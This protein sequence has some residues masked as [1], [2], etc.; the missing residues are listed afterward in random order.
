M[1][2]DLPLVETK[3]VCHRSIFNI[4]FTNLFCLI[5]KNFIYIIYFNFLVIPH[6]HLVQKTTHFMFL[7][8]RVSVHITVR[9]HVA[10]RVYMGRVEIELNLSLCVWE[11]FCDRKEERKLFS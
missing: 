7:I 8:I 9:F 1:H 2:S 3:K 6:V 5:S 4:F 10:T 11:G